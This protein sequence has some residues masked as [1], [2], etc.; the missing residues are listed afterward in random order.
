MLNRNNFIIGKLIDPDT[1]PPINGLLVT[2]EGTAETDGH[3]IIV[4][5]APASQPGLLPL[6]PDADNIEEAQWF[7]PFVLDKESAVKLSKVLPKPDDNQAREMAIVDVST[8]VDGTATLAANDDE[9]RIIVKAEKVMGKFP[10]FERIFPELDKAQFEITFD[11]AILV[12]VLKAFEKFGNSVTLR[13][14][15]MR[16]MRIDAEAAGQTMRALVMPMRTVAA[17]QVV[18]DRP[19]LDEVLPAVAFEAT[20]NLEAAVDESQRKR[21]SSTLAPAHVAGG[22]HQA[23]KRKSPLQDNSVQ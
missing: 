14:Y 3:Q 1:M 20:K 4:V 16:G 18:D 6:F 13:L 9:R 11:P 8:E 2:P 5:S 10:D 7:S 22:T 12:P 17:D 15:G 23:R 19:R 21:E